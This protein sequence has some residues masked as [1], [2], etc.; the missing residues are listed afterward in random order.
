MMDGDRFLSQSDH[1]RT[2]DSPE[3]VQAY[4]D[5]IKAITPGYVQ[6]KYIEAA[7]Q[8]WRNNRL[9]LR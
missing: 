4:V 1:A 7:R 3:Q 5:H 2:L 9:K 6:Q 8:R